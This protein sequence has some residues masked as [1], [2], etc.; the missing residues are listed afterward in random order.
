[1]FLVLWWFKMW[2]PLCAFILCLQNMPSILFSNMSIITGSPS[3]CGSQ[4]VGQIVW[5]K[6]C[7]SHCVGQLCDIL[8]HMCKHCD[9]FVICDILCHLWHLAQLSKWWN[10][11][12]GSST[13]MLMAVPLAKNVEILCTEQL[14][15][16]S[17][18]DTFYSYFHANNLPQ[19]TKGKWSAFRYIW[20][21]VLQVRRV[22][23]S[24]RE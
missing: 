17:I 15:Q 11:S 5:V 10:W 13:V 20:S 1:M 7:R 3:P 8:C 14:S 16:W 23:N 6:M 19:E 12:I 21:V 4:C 24:V 2:L 22:Q 18:S 9:I